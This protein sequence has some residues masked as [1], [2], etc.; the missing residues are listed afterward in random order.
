MK[1]VVG[2][3]LRFAVFG[4]VWL[5]LSGADPANIPYGVI[6]V[7][8]TTALSMALLPPA[9]P[10]IRR[11]P[12]RLWGTLVL[13]AW[14]LQQSIIG[15][16]DV[17]RRAVWPKVDIE[18]AVV[19]V[20]VTLPQGPAQQLSLL[21]MNLLPGSMVQHV[22]YVEDK[23][24]AEIHTLSL[25]LEPKKQWAALQHRVQQAFQT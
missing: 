17:A 18:P 5:A 24:V 2:S 15:G 14:F 11:W 9:Q 1:W 3:L 20:H 19:D 7:A 8:A 6:A 22:K 16:F 23:P 25:D 13:V 21:L 10:T 4:L 12:A